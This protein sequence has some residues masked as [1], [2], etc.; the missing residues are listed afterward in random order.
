MRAIYAVSSG[1]YSDYQIDAVFS[2]RA[3]A[4]KYID[5][6]PSDDCNGIEEMM[7]DRP[8]P[9]ALPLWNVRMLRDGSIEGEIT[10]CDDMDSG[11]IRRYVYQDRHQVWRRSSAP[12]YEGMGVPDC[13]R[14]IV[15]AKDE[16]HAIKIVNDQRAQLI[17]DGEWD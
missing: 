12:A 10:R 13:L 7:L 14:S 17:A 16:T 6:F 5:R 2:T 15:W 8:L 9:S 11:S 3:K 4:Q 1:S